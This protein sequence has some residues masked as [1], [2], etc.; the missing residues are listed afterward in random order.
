M[1]EFEL[2]KQFFQQPSLAFSNAYLRQGIGD[3]CAT[4]NIPSEYDLH[5]SLDTLV[6]GV[7]F[8]HHANPFDIATR[9]LAVTISD[10]AAMAATPIAFTLGITLPSKD[11][12]WLKQFSDGLVHAAQYYQCPLIGGD[13]TKGPSLVMSLQVHGITKKGEGLKRSGAQVGDKVYVSN[14]LGDGAGALPLVL[15]EPRL[16]TGLAEHFYKPIAQIKFAQKIKSYA[17]SCLDISDGLIQDL[18]HICKASHVAMNIEPNLIPLSP[19][20]IQTYGREQAL[21]YALT[22][23]DDYQLAYTAKQCEQGVCIGEVVEGDNVTVLGLDIITDGF[24]HF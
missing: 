7:H 8:P 17:S 18:N 13:T 11:E 10:L 14:T 22:G 6:E 3:D 23:G 9:A 12:N 5:L 24:Q 15:K 4:L 19:L 21:K 16:N 2:I 20:L 1:N